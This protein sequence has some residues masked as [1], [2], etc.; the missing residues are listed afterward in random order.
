M[1]G[2]PSKLPSNFV[3]AATISGSTGQAMKQE[4]W[5]LCR[6]KETNKYKEIYLYVFIYTHY[7]YGINRKMLQWQWQTDF[8]SVFGKSSEKAKCFIP[9]P[10]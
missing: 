8:F 4:K 3:A 9:R 10:S 2:S 1:T 6:S 7:A 5:N